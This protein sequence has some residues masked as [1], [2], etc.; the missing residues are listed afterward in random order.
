MIRKEEKRDG[1]RIVFYVV[2]NDINVS[3]IISELSSMGC[4]GEE[5]G[6]AYRILTSD[7]KGYFY[8]NKDAKEKLLVIDECNTKFGFDSN[9]F[10][11]LMMMFFMTTVSQL[12]N[13]HKD[14]IQEL[15]RSGE[16]V[17]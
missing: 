16:E 1:E 5:L 12:N 11:P 14:F 3:A 9:L 15:K 4:K 8:E 7:N 17:R 13:A 6:D 2:N 10:L